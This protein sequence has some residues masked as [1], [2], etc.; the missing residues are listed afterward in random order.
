[1]EAEFDVLKISR[2]SNLRIRESQIL[3]EWEKKYDS[4]E[5]TKFT[6]PVCLS[7]LSYASS[8][9][10]IHLRYVGSRPSSINRHAIYRFHKFSDVAMSN[11]SVEQTLNRN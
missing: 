6:T 3:G 8:R 2:I 11:S 9:D 4:D 5:I 7:N 1:M 10:S